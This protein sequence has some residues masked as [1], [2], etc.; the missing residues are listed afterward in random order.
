MVDTGVHTSPQRAVALHVDPRAAGCQP[1][2]VPT[3]EMWPPII[4]LVAALVFW[5]YCLVDF[6]RT[7]EWEIRTVPRHVWVVLL[8]FGS[9]AGGIAW[10]MLGRPRQRL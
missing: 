10:W 5:A 2:R 4:V 3:L 9:V 7:A 6:T 1:R 8:V